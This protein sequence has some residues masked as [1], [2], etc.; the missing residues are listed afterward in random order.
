MVWLVLLGAVQAWAQDE[1]PNGQVIRK[2]VTSSSPDQQYSLYLP[3]S[4]SVDRRWPL[5]IVMDPRGKAPM[6]LNLFVEE[7]EARG[8][9]VMSSYQSRSD[10]AW[11]VTTE[12]LQALL[13]ESEKRYAVDHSRVYLAGFSGTSKAA[14]AYAN[15]LKGTV[16]GVFGVAGARPHLIE[17][18]DQEV[19]FD[20]FGVTGTTDFNHREMVELSEY[21]EQIGAPHR[22]EIFEGGHRWPPPE[23]SNLALDWFDLQAM[24]DKRIPTENRFVDDHLKWAIDRFEAADEPLERRRRCFEIVRDFSGLRD[25][26]AYEKQCQALGKDPSVKQ[27]LAKQKKLFNQETIYVHKRLAPWL[28]TVRRTDRSPPSV[29]RSLIELQIEPLKKKAEQLEDPETA[30]HAQRLLDDVYANVSFYLPQE[31]RQGGDYDRAL[32]ALRIAVEVAPEKR[33]AHWALAEIYAQTGQTGSAIE[34]L[35]KAIAMGR[36][37]IERLKTDPAWESL[38]FLPTW[39]ALIDQADSASH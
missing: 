39:Q 3:S 26:D 11:S 22:L 37:D 4:Y 18:D 30:H 19:E 38:R 20:Y 12:A 8:Y 24:R 23:I 32:L 16:A 28:E 10:T 1:V 13:Q 25:V 27:A 9:V 36:V 7:A 6:A 5:L 33:R 35:T 15:A 34:A 29:S 31:F 14:W 2:I 17:V 21:L